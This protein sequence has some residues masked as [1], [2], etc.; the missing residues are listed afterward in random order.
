M[1]LTQ[2]YEYVCMLLNYKSMS[3][4]REVGLIEKGFCTREIDQVYYL[5]TLLIA[6]EYLKTR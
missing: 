3:I 1:G 4:R 5:Q 6:S 2:I